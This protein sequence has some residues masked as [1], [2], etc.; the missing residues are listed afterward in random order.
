[1]SEAAPAS[2]GTGSRKPVISSISSTWLYSPVSSNRAD[3]ETEAHAFVGVDVQ[4]KP[5]VYLSFEG[6]YMWADAGLSGDFVGF[7]PIDLSGLRI[8]AGIN[9]S[10]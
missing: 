3:S 1:M 2:F 10:F 8:T 9:Y 6:R 7:D 4:L 5:A